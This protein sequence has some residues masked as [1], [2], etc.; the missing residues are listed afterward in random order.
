MLDLIKNSR[1]VA[2]DLEMTGISFG[3]VGASSSSVRPQEAYLQAKKVA[4]IFGIVQIGLTFIPEYSTKAFN[5][6]VSSELAVKHVQPNTVHSLTKV[7]DRVLSVSMQSL[8]FLKES[9]FDLVLRYIFEALV[10]G[11]FASIIRGEWTSESSV[12]EGHSNLKDFHRDFDAVKCEESLQKNRPIIVG[13]NLF[14]DLVFIYRTFFGPLPEK[15]DDFLVEIHTLFPR[16]AD[17][18]YM[19]TRNRLFESFNRTCQFPVY[20]TVPGFGYKEL[21]GRE[22]TA[23]PATDQQAK[24]GHAHMAG[25]DSEMTGKLFLKL[26]CRLF[27]GNEHTKLNSENIYSPSSSVENGTAGPGSR[28]AKKPLNSLLDDDDISATEL[29]DLQL[30][31][32]G[33]VAAP[34]AKP[35]LESMAGETYSPRE[36]H[37]L[38]LW[39][40]H[41]WS[42]YGNKMRVRGA[43]AISLV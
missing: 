21:R 13:H 8:K 20:A 14:H 33:L 36:V 5:I 25:Y 7:L 42:V 27:S 39:T 11:C 38:P 26:A 22:S 34:S 18:K 15:L 24:R 35:E 3:D 41:F 2:I 23:G 19:A 10:G 9:K 6:P 1:F 37:M 40:N 31:H 32:P 12:P 16:V 28:G 4:E 29:R 17:T 43:G 30:K